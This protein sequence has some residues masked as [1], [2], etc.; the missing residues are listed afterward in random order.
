[1]AKEYLQFVDKS[2]CSSLCPCEATQEAAWKANLTADVLKKYERTLSP[3]DPK[4]FK[5]DGAK[6][7]MQ[8]GPVAG[9]GGT[10]KEYKDFATCYTEVLA[11]KTTTDTSAKY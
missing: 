1:M 10:K 6:V 8:F 9:S 2:M 5:T 11:K 4:P 7:K 3:S